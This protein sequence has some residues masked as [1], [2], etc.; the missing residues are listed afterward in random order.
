MNLKINLSL[1]D[2]VGDC[3]VMDNVISCVVKSFL[4]TGNNVN[5][6]YYRLLNTTILF[7]IGHRLHKSD[8]SIRYITEKD[9]FFSIF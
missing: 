4:G 9:V 2:N 7:V 6:V 5:I 3:D 1:C 8:A